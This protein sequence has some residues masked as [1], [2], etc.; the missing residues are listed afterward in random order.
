M[1]K[2]EENKE[3]KGREEGEEVRNQAK[4]RERR[5]FQCCLD[6]NHHHQHF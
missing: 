6:T 2:E 4:D 1:D 3:K 5:V